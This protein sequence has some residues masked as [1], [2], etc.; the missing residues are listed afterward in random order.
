M[1]WNEALYLYHLNRGGTFLG[2]WGG[3]WYSQLM[4]EHKGQPLVIRGESIPGDRS[5]SML[6]R[7]FLPLELEQPYQLTVSRHSLLNRGVNLV[8]AR[9]DF[10]YPE[11]SQTRRIRTDHI[12]FTRQVLRDLELRQ[13]LE[14]CPDLALSVYPA[15]PA[16]G[17]AHVLDVHGTVSALDSGVSSDFFDS[18]SFSLD[19]SRDELQQYIDTGR[20]DIGEFQANLDK[21]I[22]LTV[23]ARDALNRWPIPPM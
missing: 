3:K 4:L 15:V 18:I 22:A 20:Y 13:A 9:E 21:M 17:R 1:H 5:D 16:L 23:A 2:P 12:P 8:M 10:G 11:I 19:L 7:A 14:R 6:T